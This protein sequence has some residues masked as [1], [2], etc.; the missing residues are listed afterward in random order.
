MTER[1]L[2]AAE[3]ALRLLEG[4]EFLDAQNLMQSDPAFANEVADWEVRLAPLADEIGSVRPDQA[5][6]ERIQRAIAG[7][8]ASI[9]KL[10]RK[11][12]FWKLGDPVGENSAS[13]VHRLE[14]AWDV[15]DLG[16]PQE[17]SVILQFRQI[18]ERRGEH[19]PVLLPPA[20]CSVRRHRHQRVYE[21]LVRAGVV[22][23]QP[24]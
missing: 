1:E 12:R 24:A 19:G 18:E 4:Q 20:P 16:F 13:V 8:G 2:L 7:S 10:Q 22:R 15:E 11:L 5:M 6:W 17:R 21:L 3:M 23:G 9:V 14:R